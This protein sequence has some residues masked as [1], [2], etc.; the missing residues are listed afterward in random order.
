ADQWAVRMRDE[1]GYHKQL[2]DLAVW[3]RGAERP[4]AIVGDEGHRR[5]DRQRMILEGWRDA[6]L[7]GQYAAVQYDCGS[8]AAVARIRRVA[9]RAR[10]SPPEF[11]AAA[12]RSADEIRSIAPDPDVD[13]AAAAPQNSAQGPAGGTDDRADGRQLDRP[14]GFCVVYVTSVCFAAPVFAFRSPYAAVGGMTIAHGLQ[15]LVL[16]GLVAAGARDGR[17]RLLRLAVLCN[18]A[19]IGGIALNAASHLH[20]GSAVARA[21]FGAYLGAV[22]AHFV[23]DAGLWRLRDPFPRRFLSLNV[24]YLVPPRR[25]RPSSV[26]DRSAP[27]I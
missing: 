5:E 18:V 3:R 2:P 21:V 19:L 16:V 17:S 13:E 12:Q 26:D 27:D 11:I 10:L 6:I 15:Y 14:S 20:S 25:E 23:V 8:D 24:P 7:A 1:R 4:V 22:M 9:K